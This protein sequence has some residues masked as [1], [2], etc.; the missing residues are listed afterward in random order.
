MWSGN[1]NLKKWAEQFANGNRLPSIKFDLNVRYYVI[2]QFK[3][4]EMYLRMVT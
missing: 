3:I 4:D 1:R 2:N